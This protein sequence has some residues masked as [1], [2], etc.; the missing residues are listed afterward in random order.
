MYVLRYHLA[1]DSYTLNTH[2]TVLR[3]W[4]SIA[5]YHME[6]WLTYLMIP[7][8][9]LPG[10]YVSG[11]FFRICSMKPNHLQVLLLTHSFGENKYIHVRNTYFMSLSHIFPPV[12]KSWEPLLLTIAFFSPLKMIV[13]NFLKMYL[14]IILNLQ[15]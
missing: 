4:T 9:D 5:S 15:F 2:I 7:F 11:S 6:T 14:E 10:T 12:A 3:V 13:K 8:L 1:L